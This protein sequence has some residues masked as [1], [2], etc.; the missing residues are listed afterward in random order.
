MWYEHNI[1]NHKVFC[2]KQRHQSSKELGVFVSGGTIHAT[3]V[4]A[5]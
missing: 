2:P 3:G 1:K 5:Y 4:D